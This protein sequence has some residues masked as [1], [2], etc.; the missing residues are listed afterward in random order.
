[1]KLSF[2]SNRS[3]NYPPPRTRGG[4]SRQRFGSALLLLLL[5]T[6]LGTSC[7]LRQLKHE[8]KQLDARGVLAV[9]VS[10]LP[11]LLPTYA[12]AWPATADGTN[13]MLGF[14]QVAADGVA[15]FLLRQNQNYSVGAFTDLNTNG[16]YDGG[17][18]VAY[19]KNLQP[20][21]LSDPAA[22][23]Q[24]LVLP[25]SPTNGLPPGQ[26]LVL[27]RE[28]KELG[29]TL[30][31]TTGVIANLDDP[32]FSAATGELGMWR[33][34]EFLQQHKVGVYFLEPYDAKKVP[35]LFVY[36]ISGSFQDWRTVV[37]QLDRQ[38]YQPWLFQYPSGLR[39]DKS[40]NTLAGLMVLLRQQYQ[41]E[42]LVVV[43][44]SMG[45]L[46][47]RG[48]IQRAASQAGTNFIP[49]FVTISTPW[50]G[51][52]A[53]ASGV[54]HLDFPVPAWRDMSPGS[55]YLKTIL[56]QPLPPGTRH[57]LIFGFKSSGGLGMPDD[58]DGVVGV[59]S[60]L[61]IEVQNAAAS[62]FGLNLDHGEILR[63]PIV[64]EKL[65]QALAR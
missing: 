3:R 7:A 57:D 17:E 44:H 62:V 30:S 1:M 60:E 4:R 49:T 56:A 41:F 55:D 13:V 52:Q 40:A 63:S 50:G 25:L 26:S 39:L 27:P 65:H 8:V 28:D 19:I 10:P 23:R 16:V 9:Q 51:H 29:E 12:L 58:N 47:S 6:G 32:N 42:R 2:P 61:V 43:A 24:P 34:F 15:I 38:K 45:G 5:V 37:A 64:V 33:P 36:G 46:V 59:G 48:A 20:T 18:P 22:R 35:V 54:K 21:P 31:I 53:A 14:Q 11:G